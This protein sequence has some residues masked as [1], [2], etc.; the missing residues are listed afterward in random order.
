MNFWQ[1]LGIEPTGDKSAIKRAYAKL[2]KIHH[3]EDDPQ[4]YQKLREAFDRAM[5][6]AIEEEEENE[7]DYQ[8]ND[9]TDTDIDVVA[10]DINQGIRYRSTYRWTDVAPHQVLNEVQLFFQKMKEL[11]YDFARRIDPQEWNALM[12]DD[13]LWKVEYHEERLNA[14]ILFLE[15]HQ[16]LPHEVWQILDKCFRLVEDKEYLFEIYDEPTVK[17]IIRQIYGATTLGYDCFVNR[18]LHFDIEH[19]LTL[20]Q[21]AQSMLMEDQLEEAADVLAEA[22]QMFQDDPD[23][24][25]MRAKYFRRVG[26]KEEALTSL[27][28]LLTLK[29]EDYEAHLLRAQIYYEEQ[30]YEEAIRECESLREYHGLD[31]DIWSVS[32]GSKLALGLVE[33]I[34]RENAETKVN[35]K[36]YVHFLFDVSLGQSLHNKHL[37]TQK[38]NPYYKLSKKSDFKFFCIT[39]G[40]IFLRLSWLYLIVFWAV[41]L[42]FHPPGFM[43]LLYFIL[44]LSAWK[45]LRTLK[46]FCT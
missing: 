22:H 45:T 29:P 30:Q 2:L 40:V 6:I 13:F 35:S 38:Y 20:R 34:W 36:D 41:Q 25:L 32:L 15:K 1:T 39:Y 26:N 7:A 4:G 42:L 19:Y 12:A 28:D 37:F 11:Y 23:L 24:Q 27:D 18:E 9:G 16:N 10:D 44:G 43:I 31:I 17:F 8:C 21:R 33:E 46:L 14:L 5:K 3:P